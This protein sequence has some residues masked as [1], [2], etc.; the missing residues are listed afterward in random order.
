MSEPANLTDEELALI[1]RVIVYAAALEQMTVAWA[2][3][4][5]ASRRHREGDEDVAAAHAAIWKDVIGNGSGRAVTICRNELERLPRQHPEFG[6]KADLQTF[7][8]EVEELFSRR[9]GIAH[10]VWERTDNG[11]IVAY[12]ATRWSKNNDAIGEDR[13][14]RVGGTTEELREL[15][16]Q[17][18]AALV[19]V[20]DKFRRFWPAQWGSP[21]L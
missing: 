8:D 1:G 7:V 17:L 2:A 3:T 10:G 19:D 11:R 14:E 5:K 21:P 15:I 4:L 12:R 13:I 20:T 18:D 6:R 16:N 9:H